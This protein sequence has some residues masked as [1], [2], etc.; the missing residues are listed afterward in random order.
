MCYSKQ[1]FKP[2]KGLGLAVDCCLACVED[3]DLIWA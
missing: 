2:D 3:E 1:C